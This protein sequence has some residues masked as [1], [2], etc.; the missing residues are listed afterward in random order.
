M[1]WAR[2]GEIDKSNG[3]VVA[4]IITTAQLVWIEAWTSSMINSPVTK[5]PSRQ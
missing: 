5:V 1:A 2:G 4:H 3:E